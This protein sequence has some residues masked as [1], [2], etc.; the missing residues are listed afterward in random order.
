MPPL[1]AVLLATVL[2]LSSACRAPS[3]DA[4]AP[5][6]ADPPADDVRWQCGEIIVAA[7]L[8]GGRAALGM[9]GVRL[10]LRRQAPAA[11]A[12]YVDAAGN[13]F[14]VEGERATLALAGEE[15]RDCVRTE[16]SSPWDEARAHGM[17]L[18][19]SG[20]EPGWFAELAHGERP[21]LQATINYGER[22]LVVDAAQPLP[23]TAGATGFG[24]QATDGSA[25]ELRIRHEAC[26]DDMSGHPF[27]ASA[28]LVVDDR[29]Y[30]G[31]AAFLQ[32]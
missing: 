7:R 16:R 25:V 8:A 15:T 1:L 2:V 5:T 14:R 30:R 3:G 4:A 12:H 26:R 27:P 6:A 9:P 32:P 23:A 28:E 22:R 21:R 31:C 11:G 24:G 17:A 20:N 19:A 10:E 18:R 29:G 13:G